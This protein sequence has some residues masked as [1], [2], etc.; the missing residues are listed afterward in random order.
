MKRTILIFE[1]RPGVGIARVTLPELVHP[2]DLAALSHEFRDWA[3]G[4][5][6]AAHVLDLSGLS[7]MTSAAIGMLINMDAHLKARSHR[8][9]LVIAENSLT[10]EI[11]GHTHLDHLMPIRYSLD[12]ALKALE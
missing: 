5:D 4:E 1:R 12:E 2:D 8:L 7:Y 6:C 3:A 11:L 9:A 10:A